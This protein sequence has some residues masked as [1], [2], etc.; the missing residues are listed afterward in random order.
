M[1]MRDIVYASDGNMESSKKVKAN[2]NLDKV[3]SKKIAVK[4]FSKLNYDYLG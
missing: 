2:N 4:L 1:C 3:R